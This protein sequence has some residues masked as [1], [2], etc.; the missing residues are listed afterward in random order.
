M[1]ETVWPQK[2]GPDGYL[3]VQCGYLHVDDA[4]PCGRPHA[5]RWL[6]KVEVSPLAVGAGECLHPDPESVGLD[7]YADA[8]LIENVP[9]AVNWGPLDVE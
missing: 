8:P 1:T 4:C 3:A 6:C 2:P 5:R 9:E 7:C